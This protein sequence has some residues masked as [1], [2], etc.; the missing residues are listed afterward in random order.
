MK[1]QMNV[2]TDDLCE[3]SIDILFKEIGKYHVLNDDEEKNALEGLI[4]GDKEARE[5]LINSNLRLVRN[6]AKLYEWSGIPL[7]DLFQVGALALIQAVDRYDPTKGN[8]FRAFALRW[9]DGELLNAVKEHTKMRKVSIDEKA[10]DREEFERTLKEILCSDGEECVDWDI[11]YESAFKALKVKVRSLFFPEA[12]ELWADYI[13]MREKGYC[14]ADVAKKYH[15]S[16]EY[17]ERL[18]AS[19]TQAL[20]P[21]KKRRG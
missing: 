11:R 6:K 9:I 3:N 21:K 1:N 5:L 4:K 19:I 10:S 8:C 13:V 17:A 7:E 16:E 15:V 20:M 12:S 2:V 18:I 14:L